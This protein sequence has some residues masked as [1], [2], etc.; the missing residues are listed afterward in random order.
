TRDSRYG[1]SMERVLYNTIGGARLIEPDG[2]SFYYSDYNRHEAKKEWYKDKWPCCSGTFPQL[3]ADYGISSYY[4]S[5]DGIYVNLFLP[6]RLTWTRGGTQC[7]L[8]QKRSEEHTSELQS[9]AY[10]V[11][12]LLLE[13][14]KKKKKKTKK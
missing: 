13:K 14:K 4:Q 11:C 9:L 10:L 2:T 6:S 3:S 7:T 5:E 8:T 12:R 1:D